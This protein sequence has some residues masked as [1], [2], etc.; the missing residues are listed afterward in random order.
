M[1]HAIGTLRQ[2]NWW[3]SE[4]LKAVLL[5]S[6]MSIASMALQRLRLCSGVHGDNSGLRGHGD[7]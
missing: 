4:V 6:L 5:Y 3:H 1:D 2:T 7:E